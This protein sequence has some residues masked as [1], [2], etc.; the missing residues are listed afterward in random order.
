M[1]TVLFLPFL[2]LFSGHHQAADAMMERIR[3][4]NPAIVCHKVDIMH[5]SYGSLETAVSRIYIEWIKKWPSSYDWLYGKIAARE[6]GKPNYKLYTCLFE[7]FM[8]RL[9]EEKRPDLILCTHA[10]PSRLLSGMKQKGRIDIPI[11]NVYTDYFINNLWGRLNI[12]HHF[13]PDALCKQ[14]LIRQGVQPERITVTGIPVHP[15]IVAGTGRTGRRSSR[16]KVL[17]SGG[18]T[19]IGISA[20]LLNKLGGTGRIH[21]YVLC[22]ANERLAYE[23]KRRNHPHITPLSYIAGRKEMNAL[24]D[25]VD[26]VLTKPGGVTVSECLHKR[27]PVFIF[28]ALPGQEQLNLKHLLRRGLVVHLADWRT[29]ESVD[30]LIL[31][32]LT[33]KP[34]LETLRRN[35]EAYHAEL[36]DPFSLLVPGKSAGLSVTRQPFT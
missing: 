5:F 3:L 9:V 31:Q 13:A 12:D 25:R 26:A 24:Y 6:R 23:L 11:V 7:V 18:S 19:G 36:S 30:N 22:G 8:R 27:I 10:L 21:Y 32:V 15:D 1:N 14:L 29:E 28:H 34:S 35:M 33:S 4:T 2:R 20:A 17:V 16:F